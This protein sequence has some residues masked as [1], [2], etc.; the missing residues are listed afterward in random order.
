MTKIILGFAN[1][2]D[3]SNLCCQDFHQRF[4]KS[5]LQSSVSTDFESHRC[6]VLTRLPGD[7]SLQ[8]KKILLCPHYV[9]MHFTII[10]PVGSSAGTACAH[11]V[12]FHPG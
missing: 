1:L 9:I 12:H 10:K 11:P 8:N 3:F 7:F 2:A 4:L 5:H 6:E